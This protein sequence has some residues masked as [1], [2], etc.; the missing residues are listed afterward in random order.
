MA[1][2]RAQ[3][4]I[5]KVI[6]DLSTHNSIAALVLAGSQVEGNAFPPDQFSDIELYVVAFDDKHSEAE[7]LIET[8]QDRLNETHVLA[9]KN[10]WAGWSILFEDLLRLELPL[11]KA[12]D[13]QVFSRSEKQ[14][15]KVLYQKDNFK[16]KQ[17]GV[18]KE[19]RSEIDFEWLVKDFWYMAVYVAQHIGRGELWL[20]RDAMRVSMQKKIKK[21]I[22]VQNYKETI[23][24]ERDRR[25]ELTWKVQELQILHDIS[26]SYERSDIVRAFWASIKYAKIFFTSQDQHLG[27]VFSKYE[28]KLADKL[29]KII[30]GKS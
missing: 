27:A 14:K 21:M 28:Q 18:K 4:V 7:R 29:K 25:I 10:Q 19:D 13:D 2:S 15:I 24:L 6:D 11:V 17:S 30:N 20:A 3:Q 9:Y 16:I 12:S 23:D 26:C 5:N 8:I 22:Q 1:T